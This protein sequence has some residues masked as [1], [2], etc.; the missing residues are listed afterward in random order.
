MGEFP[1]TILPLKKIASRAKSI[2]SG[3]VMMIVREEREFVA[4]RITH[5]GFIVQKHGRTYLRHAAK[6]VFARVVDEDLERILD[7][8]ARYDKWRWLE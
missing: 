7:R 5:L 2:P 8:N 1:L 3:T 6:T 4:T